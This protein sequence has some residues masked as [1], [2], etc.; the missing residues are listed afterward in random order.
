MKPIF[1]KISSTVKH[2]IVF[3][4]VP[5][6]NLTQYSLLWPNLTTMSCIVMHFTF[7]S[8]PPKSFN[9]FNLN[10]PYPPRAP[11]QICHQSLAQ[12]HSSINANA[13]PI[14][15]LYL[16]SYPYRPRSSSMHGSA[17]QS[18]QAQRFPT[19]PQL[20]QY[21][22]ELSWTKSMMDFSN[23]SSLF[24]IKLKVVYCNPFCEYIMILT[25]F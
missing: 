11:F 18:F 24:T 20:L 4:L 9:H 6:R 22:S 10:S 13:F 12:P 7:N 25:H 19:Q 8:I 2:S 21:P 15:F 23:P 3:L 14:S 17:H 1:S 16:S 5:V